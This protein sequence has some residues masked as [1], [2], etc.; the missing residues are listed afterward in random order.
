MLG[1]IRVSGGQPDLLWRNSQND[2]VPHRPGTLYALDLAG[3]CL[4]AVL[5]SAWLVPMFGFLKTALL[6]A[7]VSLAGG[8]GHLRKPASSLVSQ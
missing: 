8:D 7:L 6:L 5:F 2:S 3:S 1:R 4:G